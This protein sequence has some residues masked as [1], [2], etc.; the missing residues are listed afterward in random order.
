MCSVKNIEFLLIFFEKLMDL[1][2]LHSKLMGP[3]KLM[4]MVPLT[5]RCPVTEFDGAR[6]VPRQGGV[7]GHVQ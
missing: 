5:R 2:T 7:C 4:L 3:I 1:K 6:Y